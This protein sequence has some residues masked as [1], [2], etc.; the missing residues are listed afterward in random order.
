MMSNYKTKI[1][2]PKNFFLT[3]KKL[4]NGYFFEKFLDFRKKN[5]YGLLTPQSQFLTDLDVYGLILFAT[6]SSFFCQYSYS[7]MASAFH[8]IAKCVKKGEKMEIFHFSDFLP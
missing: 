5:N 7:C 4:K 6:H 3:R 1:K 2:N 8:K